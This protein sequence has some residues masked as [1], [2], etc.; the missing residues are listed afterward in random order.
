MFIIENIEVINNLLN[1]TTLKIKYDEE[2][3]N[4]ACDFLVERSTVDTN[5]LCL[6]K[7]ENTCLSTII[8][9]TTRNNEIYSYTKEGKRGNKFN[10]FLL[11][12]LIFSSDKNLISNAVNY[13]IAYLIINNFE[14]NVD[15]VNEDLSLFYKD[16]EYGNPQINGVRPYDDLK[17]ELINGNLIQNLKKLYEQNEV[18][19]S[20]GLPFKI[21]NNDVNKQKAFEIIK[22]LSQTYSSNYSFKGGFYKLK[23]N[24]KR[25]RKTINKKRKRKQKTNKKTKKRNKK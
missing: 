23:I 11:A 7:D 4:I 19:A 20:D 8:V 9:D 18:L 16:N 1:S 14:H 15:L 17:N 6:V 22:E 2:C 12:V 24:K 13:I 21:I 3:D 10:K 25:K 5:R